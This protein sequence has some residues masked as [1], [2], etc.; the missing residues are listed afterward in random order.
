M[1][2]EA[3]Y[4]RGKAAMEKVA[5]ERVQGIVD[6]TIDVH[7]GRIENI[8][9]ALVQHKAFI[10]GVTAA[11]R[12]FMAEYKALTSPDQAQNAPPQERGQVY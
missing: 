6:A 10:D 5:Q 11:T 3:L 1:S 4:L 8:G 9:M 2:V 7:Q 12:A